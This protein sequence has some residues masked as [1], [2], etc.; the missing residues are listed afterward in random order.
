MI[1]DFILMIFLAIVFVVGLVS[2][3][4]YAMKK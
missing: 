4:L 2:F 3:L 1:L